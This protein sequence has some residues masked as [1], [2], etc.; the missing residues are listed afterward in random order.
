MNRLLLQ[1]G[2][3]F[4]FLPHAEAREQTPFYDHA[5]NSEC[6]YLTKVTAVDGSH[7]TFAIT[8]VLR[9]NETETLTLRALDHTY[10]VNSEWLLAGTYAAS[11]YGKDSLGWA[12]KNDC[13]WVQA[14]VIRDNGVAYFPD[15][16][17]SSNGL[18]PNILFPG[19]SVGLRVEHLKALLQSKPAKN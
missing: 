7:V 4:A 5:L 16:G 12:M 18:M 11:A 2:L 17:F 13:A 19:G 10:S 9:G 1:L 8:E 6:V 14:R 3:L 15:W